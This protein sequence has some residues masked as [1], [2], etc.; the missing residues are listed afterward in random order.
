VIT[1]PGVIIAHG[2]GDAMSARGRS[3]V[4]AR[5][6]TA[7][8][9]IDRPETGETIEPDRPWI[10]IVWNDPINLMSYVTYV[11]QKL[12]GYSRPKAQ[13]LMMKVHVEGRA[14]VSGGARERAEADCARLHQHGLWATMER[15]S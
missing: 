12:F 3:A 13:R 8:E 14:V 5:T 1:A 15:S 4:V 11:L 2:R 10:V 9:R 7:P 6:T